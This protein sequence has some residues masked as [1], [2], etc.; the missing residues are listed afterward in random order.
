MLEFLRDS[1]IKIINLILGF[2]IVKYIIQNI[3]IYDYNKYNLFISILALLN[4]SDLGLITSYRNYLID[5]IKVSVYNS[6]QT[7]VL[8]FTFVLTL[9]FSF[10]GNYLLAISSILV[11]IRVFLNIHSQWIYINKKTHLIYITDFIHRFLFLLLLYLISDFN[12]YFL[13][14]LWSVIYLLSGVILFNKE[15]QIKFTLNFINNEWKNILPIIF[16]PLLSFISFSILEL[17]QNQFENTSSISL[18]I[19]ISMLIVPFV[20][21][22]VYSNW[23]NF[24]KINF[25]IVLSSS[26]AATFGAFILINLFFPNQSES[27]TAY[28]FMFFFIFFSM[29]AQLKLWL[30]F[31]L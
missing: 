26:L 13:I 25:T 24:R 2:F 23:S 1:F 4:Y 14:F 29:Y 30:K 20:N 3:I 31:N 10:F 12:V 22:Y 15:Y 19:R 17:F 5:K 27:F 18:M 11:G 21:V 28:I 9:S 16:I 6:A 8:I 7:R